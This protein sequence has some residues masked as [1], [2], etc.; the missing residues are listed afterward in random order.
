MNA[1]SQVTERPPVTA[2]GGCVHCVY[3]RS[4]EIRQTRGPIPIV[5]R[6]TQSVMTVNGR[7]A[8][9]DKHAARAVVS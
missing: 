3:E 4:D 8:L 2:R 9:C 7:R 1:T 6:A 5:P